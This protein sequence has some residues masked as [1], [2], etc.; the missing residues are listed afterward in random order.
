MEETLTIGQLASRAGLATSS[1]RFYERT[2]VL[3]K[4]ERVGGRR[5]YGP[6][7]I[8]RL[9]VLEV[10]KRAGFSLDEAKL[11]LRTADAGTPTFEAVREL[12]E[13]KL[14]EVE[15]LIARAEDM[16]SWLLAATD[17]TCTSLDVCGL[18]EKQ[19]R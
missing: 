12:A 4:A 16:R 8:R 3:P 14:P 2:G 15:A 18:F 6:D 13:R 19:A 11:L 9:E 5:R 17:C 10:A 7:A 1:I